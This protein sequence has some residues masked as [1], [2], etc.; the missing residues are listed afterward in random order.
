MN[1]DGSVESLINALAVKLDW[2]MKL[3]CAPVV[4][5]VF[6]SKIYKI[7]NL[8]DPISF[9]SKGDM[10]CVFS[11]ESGEPALKVLDWQNDNS[12]DS[13]FSNLNM[14]LNAAFS[15]YE[16][17]V[18]IPVYFS[19]SEN[20]I[21]RSYGSIFGL[22]SSLCLPKK[23]TISIPGNVVDSLNEDQLSQECSRILGLCVFRHL[24]LNMI[25]Y[26]K[27]LFPT[28]TN[29]SALDFI[30]FLK[31]NDVSW[32]TFQDVLKIT[33]IEGS[34]NSQDV[35]SFYSR[36]FLSPYNGSQRL[37]Y[38]L[39]SVNIDEVAGTG[40]TSVSSGTLG[41]TNA[42][43][44]QTVDC[45]LE[46]TDI[47]NT[48]PDHRFFTFDASGL[49]LFMVQWK[50]DQAMN[51]FGKDSLSKSVSYEFQKSVFAVIYHF[52]IQSHPSIL[53]MNL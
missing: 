52:L 43:D 38:P 17:A 34:S 42:L 27:Q 25:K 26:F 1:K 28:K 3:P 33:L 30:E 11:P 15:P 2:D 16:E 6:D 35:D 46:N 24:L 37:I 5:E 36:E 4:F 23:L 49:K 39:E 50:S 19:Y 41:N 22:P 40:I 48:E 44:S 31:E 20:D 8:S 7:Y 32:N 18:R 53:Q 10:I 9:F 12:L 14:D 47:D 51:F 13:L 45:E 29:P 21:P